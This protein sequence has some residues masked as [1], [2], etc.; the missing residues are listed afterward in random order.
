MREREIS[1]RKRKREREVG[2]SGEKRGG[3]QQ[4]HTGNAHY[5]PNNTLWSVGGLSY[6][7]LSKT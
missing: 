7:S 1:E 3:G 6:V 5:L 4:K 2:F